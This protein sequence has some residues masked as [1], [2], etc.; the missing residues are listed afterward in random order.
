[1]YE[2]Q[3]STAEQLARAIAAARGGP[4]RRV[5]KG[6]ECRCPAHDDHDPSLSVADGQTGP[7]VHCHAGCSQEAVLQALRDMGLWQSKPRPRVDPMRPRGIPAEWHGMPFARLYTY[8]TQQ[9]EI[10]GYV[11]R[12]E[13]GQGNKNPIP[14]FKK[15]GDRWRPGAPDE[16][17]P[18]YGLPSL[19]KP[20]AVYVVEGE[21]ACDAMTKR[22]H[23]CVTNQGGSKAPGKSD[24]TPL[25][26]RDV[27][28]WPD[29][30]EPGKQHAQAVRKLLRGIA[31]S[32]R[33]VDVAA[34]DPDKEGWDAADWDGVG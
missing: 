21:K 6:Y 3:H 32:V 25:T 19:S 23:A 34:M 11:A 28:V 29:Y 8:A 30:D 20:G 18:L 4:V 24:W 9:G 17:R 31:S 22:G 1:M 2:P 13:D 27:I 5:S 12:Y 7:L 15:E 16:P 33:L 10:L 26:G 14:F